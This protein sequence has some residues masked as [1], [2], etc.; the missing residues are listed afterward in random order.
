MNTDN[1]SIE[2]LA[3]FLSL[4][5]TTVARDDEKTKNDL[6]SRAEE[7]V[8]VLELDL[9]GHITLDGR[10]PLVE[11]CRSGN[12]KIVEVGILEYAL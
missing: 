6:A 3:T 1:P 4:C 5:Q 12:M 8:D 10:H 2:S 9:R 7:I 11:A